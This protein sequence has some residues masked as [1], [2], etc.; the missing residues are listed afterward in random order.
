MPPNSISCPRVDGP[1]L[2]RFIVPSTSSPTKVEDRRPNARSFAPKDHQKQEKDRG[3]PSAPSTA[4]GKMFSE[5]I[6]L[7]VAALS[8]GPMCVKDWLCRRLGLTS[9]TRRSCSHQPFSV[10]GRPLVIINQNFISIVNINKVC[11]F[12]SAC[13]GVGP[14][15]CVPVS[16]PDSRRIRMCVHPEDLV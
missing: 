11:A 5:R 3:S 12:D 10:I 13:V 15:G 7:I 1:T 8:L 2:R 6:R 4:H 9:S 14:L 16:P